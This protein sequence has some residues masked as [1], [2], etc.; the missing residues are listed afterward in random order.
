MRI[1][2]QRARNGN[3]LLL[4]AG[5]LAGLVVHALCQADFR[6]LLDG[7][8]LRFFLVTLKHFLLRQHDVFLR[9]QVREQI[10]ALEDHAQLGAHRIDVGV[11]RG[12]FRILEENLTTGGFF[13]AIDAT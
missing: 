10:E 3:A 2:R 6:Q 11:L 5:K 13:Q 9:G 4:A 1:H 7:N 12:D 8:F